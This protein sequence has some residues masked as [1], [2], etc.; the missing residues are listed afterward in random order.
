VG[1]IMLVHWLEDLFNSTDDD[2][3]RDVINGSTC[4]QLSALSI[5]LRRQMLQAMIDGPT[6]DDDENAI[7][8]LLECSPCDDVRTL[9]SQIG[10]VDTLLDEF[11]GSEW[12]RLMLRLQQCNLVD[13]SDWDDDA[14]RLFINSSDCATLNALRLTDIRHLILNMFSGSTGDDDENAIIRLIGCLPCERRRELM[15]MSDMSYDDFDDE[16]DGSEWRSLSGLL[17]CV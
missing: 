4:S 13:F 8:R 2:Q 12:D 14:T 16:V 1:A 11:Q 15:L 7:A 3:A 10:G 17:N 9:V 5:E 6:G